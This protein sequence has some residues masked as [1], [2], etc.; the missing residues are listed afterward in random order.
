[1]KRDMDL[2]RRI[3]LAMEARPQAEAGY[4]LKVDGC[5]AERVNYHVL[6]L[7]EAGLITAIDTGLQWLPVDLT[8]KGHEFLDA[9]R[10][11]RRWRRA[12]SIVER[13]KGAVPFQVLEDLLLRLAHDAVVKPSKKR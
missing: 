12:A 10:D 5:E 11:E 6:L 8:W 13:Q 2:V 7:Q 3:L 1:M 4:P 9:A